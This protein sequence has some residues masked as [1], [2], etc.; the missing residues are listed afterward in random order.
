M[1][2]QTEGYRKARLRYLDNAPLPYAY[3]ST[4][5]VTYFT[6]HR[7]PKPRARRVFYFHRPETFRE[8]LKK[9]QSLRARLHDIPVLNPG[10][11]RVCQ[12]TA[13]TKLE[14]SFREA[15]PRALIQ[16]ATGAGKTYTAI[17]FIYLLLKFADAKRVLFLVD[18]KN[19]GEQA[20][21]EFMAYEPG[22][23]KRK[24]TELYNVQRLTSRYVAADSQVC[25][26]TIQRLYSILKDE[27]LDE[28]AE[29]ENPN[30]SR[31]QAK[32]PAP[33]GYNEKIPIE[34]FD[35]I[36]VDEC[37]RSIYNLW[38]TRKP[39]WPSSA[40]SITRASP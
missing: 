5:E 26:S 9:S 23:D 21:Q 1:E 39:S 11:L 18:T 25:I 29:E 33:V 17:T 13:I 15:R 7:D 31:W 22:D 40:P 8:W 34:F 10:Q 30:E 14:Q 6:N 36:V 19:L 38:K 2:E 37:H 32:E 28:G 4:G 24:F 20:E 12:I 27:E 35:F 16:M 3:E